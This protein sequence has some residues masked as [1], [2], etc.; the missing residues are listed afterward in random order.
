KGYHCAERCK[1]RKTKHARIRQ[2]IAQQTLQCAAREPKRGADEPGGKCAGQT[3]LP[4]NGSGLVITGERMRE[5]HG[6][7]GQGCKLSKRDDYNERQRKARCSAHVCGNARAIIS[8]ASIAYQ[9]SQETEAA[10]SATERV[11]ASAARKAGWREGDHAFICVRPV[12]KNAV[13]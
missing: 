9:A 1:A 7:E 11:R 4:D 2:R 5:R 8:A 12:S 13:A 6:P 10:G 3:D